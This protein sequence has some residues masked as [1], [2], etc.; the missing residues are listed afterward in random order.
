[1]TNWSE[2]PKGLVQRFGVSNLIY[3]IQDDL[4]GVSTPTVMPA[5]IVPFKL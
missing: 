1:M 3:D 4:N 2:D 5:Q